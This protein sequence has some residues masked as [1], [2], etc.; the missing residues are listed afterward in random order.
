MDDR[1][2]LDDFYCFP[3]TVLSDE[4]RIRDPETQPGRPV[5]LSL[6]DGEIDFG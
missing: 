2:F 6:F 3:G 5:D 4:D 1:Q